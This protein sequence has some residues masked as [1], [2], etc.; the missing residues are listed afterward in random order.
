[1]AWFYSGVLLGPALSPVLA[2]VFTEYTSIT[3]R[4]TQY[5]LCAASALAVVLTALFLPETSHPPLPH[6]VLKKERGKKFVLYV[7]N[8]L[9][10][11]G[12]LRYVNI[13]TTTI[14]SCC[15]MLMTYCIMVPMSVIFQER[16]HISNVAIAGCVYLSTGVGTLIG[17]RTGGRESL[18]LYLLTI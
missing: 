17:S 5:F 18:R 3:W 15:I 16:Y 1:M 12:L 4:A 14:A 2:G 13:V 10:S 7:F 11:L 8:P 6:D 9:T